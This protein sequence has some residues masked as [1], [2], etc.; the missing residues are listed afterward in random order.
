MDKHLAETL[1]LGLHRSR[2]IGNVPDLIYV[3]TLEEVVGI[4]DIGPQVY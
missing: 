1:A 3:E 4:V 2:Q